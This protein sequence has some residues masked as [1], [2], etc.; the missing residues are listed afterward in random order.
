MTN[1][2][3]KPDASTSTRYEPYIESIVKLAGDVAGAKDPAGRLMARERL[4]YGIV[5]DVFKHAGV[6]LVHVYWP[7]AE[8]E[9]WV[10]SEDL[11]QADERAR[12]LSIYRYDEEGRR[13][14]DRCKVISGVGLNYNWIV[15]F[16]PENV[17]R[18][19][20]SDGL[21]WTF[22]WHPILERVYP[23][24]TVMEDALAED[25]HAEALTVAELSTISQGES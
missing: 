16:F 10:A 4:G 18:T 15:E 17:I 12:L 22:D 20:R 11:E 8:L 19:E 2:A 25:A 21:A 13:A 1:L 24:G 3:I 14:L 9:T 7:S 5:R 23:H 6:V